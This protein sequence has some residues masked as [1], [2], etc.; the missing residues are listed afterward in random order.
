MRA[1][2]MARTGISK[3]CALLVLA[4][5][6]LG[7]LPVTAAGE[8]APLDLQT[9]LLHSA[10]TPPARVNFHEE[11]HN[12]LLQEPLLLTGYLE[13][14]QA[15]V[16]RKVVETPFQ[17]AFRIDAE[18]VLIE[19]NGETRKLSL[20]KNGSLRTIL[21]VIKAI[22]GGEAEQIESLFDYELS[23]SP[24]SWSLRLVPKSKRISRQLTSILVRGD[25]AAANS[26]RID[27]KDGEWYQMDILQDDPER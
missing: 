25:V 2:S 27:L 10:V 19:R 1:Q 13:Y 14:L 11:R 12:P 16:L 17:E 4:G 20:S 6:C 18:H 26:M 23:G 15:G 8:V 21:D 5:L 9:V 7:A 24:A 3:A 22:L